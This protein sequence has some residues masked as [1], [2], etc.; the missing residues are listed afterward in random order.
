[1]GFDTETVGFESLIK[2][3]LS[4]F[5]PT[6]FSV[7]ITYDGGV[8]S[9]GENAAVKG[10]ACENQVKQELPG[11]GCILYKCFSATDKELAYAD[12][13]MEYGSSSP[14]STLHCW[15]D[16]MEDEIVME[17]NVMGCSSLVSSVIMA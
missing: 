9:W 15:E 8:H 10:Y 4:C 6:E 2:R 13:E 5:G 11:G 12:K 17:K 14:K 3:V 16:V 7:A 1:M